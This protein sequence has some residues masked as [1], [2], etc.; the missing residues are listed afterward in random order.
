MKKVNLE[1][2]PMTLE[3][4]IP[5][6]LPWKRDVQIFEK[7]T[8]STMV[9]TIQCEI[10]FVQEFNPIYGKLLYSN[11]AMHVMEIDQTECRVHLL[12]NSSEPFALT[13][14]LN[15][16]CLEVLIDQRVLPG[17]KWDRNLVGLFSLEHYCLQYQAFILHA[18]YIIHQNHAI[19]FTAP[20][21]TGKSTQADLWA[22]Y[23]NAEIINGDRVLLYYDGTEWKAAGFPVCGSSLFCENHTASVKAIVCLEQSKENTLV[24][25]SPMTALKKIYSQAFVNKWNAKDC[26]KITELITS[27][28]QEVPVYN[29]SCTKEKDAVIYLE[30]NM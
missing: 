20:S 13:H 12:P 11:P 25:L 2:T 28:V 16:R 4:S 14:H 10:K 18:S 5:L 21:G 30:K 29:Y 15:N 1:I 17:L 22:R 7:S 27:L 19:I 23:K 26:S 8:T 24:S 3:V 9:P 6:D